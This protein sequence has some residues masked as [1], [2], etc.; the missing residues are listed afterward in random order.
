MRISVVIKKGDFV[1]FEERM[2][3]IQVLKYQGSGF[4]AAAFIELI[5]SP[6]S[7]TADGSLVK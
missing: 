7:I 3:I 1:V 4:L 5:M 2:I 6:L